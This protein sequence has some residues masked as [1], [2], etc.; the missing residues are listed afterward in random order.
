MLH[1][2]AILAKPTQHRAVD[3]Q[4]AQLPEMNREALA[5]LGAISST[6]S[7]ARLCGERRSFQSWRTGFRR[8]P[9]GVSES[10]PPASYGSLVKSPPAEQGP[11]RR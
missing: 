5:K 4:L 1:S 10:P 9:L 7:R 2:K 6:G 11:Y 3:R 8:R